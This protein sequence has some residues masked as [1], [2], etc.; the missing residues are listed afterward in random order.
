MGLA[1][2]N[3]SN[4]VIDDE[5]FTVSSVV[6]L[7]EEAGERE[8]QVLRRGMRERATKTLEC[9]DSDDERRSVWTQFTDY[10]RR[11]GCQT[12]QE[13]NWIQDVTFKAA[14]V[15]IDL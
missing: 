2:C 15:N 11:V 13:D 5:C 3:R 8:N 14:Q 4:K 1:E 9:A 10:G 6:Q 12:R 7:K